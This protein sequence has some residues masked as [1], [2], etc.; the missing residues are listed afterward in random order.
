MEVLLDLIKDASPEVWAEGA[1]AAV[2]AAATDG[3]ADVALGDRSLFQVVDAVLKK[4]YPSDDD[5]GGAA[6]WRPLCAPFFPT[7]SPNFPVT[8]VHV[9]KCICPSDRG[10]NRR[11]GPA[12]APSSPALA[13][14][15]VAGRRRMLPIPF[16][17]NPPVPSLHTP[18]TCLQTPR[19]ST[20]T[21][22][23]SHRLHYTSPLPSHPHRT[24]QL[25]TTA[26]HP[27]Y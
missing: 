26:S 11:T 4:A 18:H 22:P 20:T 3:A 6:W 24:Y 7:P 17:P 15:R 5:Q 10:A 23:H 1:K 21:L 13:C 27:P 16:V 2:A 25:P 8:C 12:C 9:R 19:M 14:Y